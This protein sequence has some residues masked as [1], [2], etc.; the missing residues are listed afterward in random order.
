[1]LPIPPELQARFEERLAKRLIPNGMHGVNKKWLRYYLDFC[2]KYRFPPTHKESLPRFIH[3][4]QEKKQT[5][6]QQQQAT[7]AIRLYHETLGAKSPSKHEPLSQPPGPERIL[8]WATERTFRSMSP[9]QNPFNT[10]KANLLFLGSCPRWLLRGTCRRH[11]DHLRQSLPKRRRRAPWIFEGN[12]SRFRPSTG[13]GQVAL[14]KGGV[15]GG[16]ADMTEEG[17]LT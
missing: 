6:A 13:S 17:R 12:P 15:N 14:R 11:I 4:L 3:K 5:N 1:M 9:E 10:K 2:Q 8:L 7:S 16:N